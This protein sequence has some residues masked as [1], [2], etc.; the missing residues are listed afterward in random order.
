MARIFA[1]VAALLALAACSESD[2]A[3]AEPQ[4]AAWED[5][6]KGDRYTE[7]VFEVDRFNDKPIDAQIKAT[8]TEII[9]E[10]VDKPDG[11]RVAEGAQLDAS[12]APAPDAEGRVAWSLTQ[13]RDVMAATEDLEVDARATKV[14]VLFVEGDYAE[15]PEG[16]RTLALSWAP[17]NIVIFRAAIFDTCGGAALDPRNPEGNGRVA[18][19]C[20]LTYTSTWVH[21]MGHL[22]GLVDNGVPMVEDHRDPDPSH[23]KH[24]VNEECVMHWANDRAELIERLSERLDLVAEDRRLVEFDAQ[25]LADLAA[26]RGD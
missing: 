6:L 8:V 20:R 21:E 5:F 9:G 10:L 19:L 22:L 12:L 14:H 7:L 17:N 23:G 15:D 16:T 13:L 25:C 18:R 11:V 3:E 1:W 24:D 2:S 4:R 26:A